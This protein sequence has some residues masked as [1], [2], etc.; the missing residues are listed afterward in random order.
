ME[1]WTLVWKSRCF[2]FSVK[3]TFTLNGK[4]VDVKKA[5]QK[6]GEGGARGGGRGGRGGGRGGPRGGGRGGKCWWNKKI[7]IQCSI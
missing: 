3:R 1:F 4:D 2:F 7:Q 6:D 5:K